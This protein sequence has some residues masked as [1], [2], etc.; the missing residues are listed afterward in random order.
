MQN[1][2]LLVFS[3]FASTRVGSEAD[4][5]GEAVHDGGGGREDGDDD[6]D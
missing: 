3:F 4:A 1:I 2:I 5:G 6:A